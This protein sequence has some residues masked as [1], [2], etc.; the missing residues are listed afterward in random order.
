MDE[1]CE[2]YAIVIVT[3]SLQQAARVSRRVAYFHLGHLV[4]VDATDKVFTNPQH[5]LDGRLHYGPHRL[6]AGPRGW[7]PGQSSTSPL[8][9]KSVKRFSENPTAM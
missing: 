9:R 2:D 7:Q 3:H 4:E 5:R 8:A 6:T 1:L